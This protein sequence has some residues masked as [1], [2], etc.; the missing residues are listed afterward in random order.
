MSLLRRLA[1]P[2]RS[3]SALRPPKRPSFPIIGATRD[4]AAPVRTPAAAARARRE[5]TPDDGS[6]TS[7]TGTGPGSVAEPST[8][9]T[10]EAPRSAPSPRPSDRRVSET[11]EVRAAARRP[12]ASAPTTIGATDAP[13]VRPPAPARASG[14]VSASAVATA[15]PSSRSDAPTGHDVARRPP[16]GDSVTVSVVPTAPPPDGDDDSSE[17]PAE[18]SEPTA[19]SD[20]E[21]SVAGPRARPETEPRAAVHPAA[22]SGSDGTAPPPERRSPTESHRSIDRADDTEQAV[23]VR[24]GTI[25][26]HEAPTVSPRRPTSGFAD[27]AAV[28]AYDWHDHG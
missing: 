28:R 9:R 12:G 3:S 8:A 4:D 11:P 10:G 17:D 26:I 2:G 21:R 25:E 18:P 24:I 1:R 20:V 7:G 5:T 13:L 22:P 16:A 19:A 14:D 23:D 6:A 15:R 27:Y